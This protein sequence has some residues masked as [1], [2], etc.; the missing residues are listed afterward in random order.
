MKIRYY[1]HVGQRTGYARAA[2]DMC[3]ALVRAGVTLEI[4]PLALPKDVS[5]TPEILPL[6]RCL[7]RDHEL[8]P[9]PDI[10]IVHT[11]P[12]DCARVIEVAMTGVDPKLDPAIPRIAY[13]TWET[14]DDAPIAIRQS[15]E[16]FQQVW[17]PSNHSLDALAGTQGMEDGAKEHYRRR[18]T[19]VPHCF[20]EESLALRR[21]V[22][23]YVQGGPG[24]RFKFYYLGAWNSRKN[25]SGLIRAFTYE[26]RPDDPVALILRSSGTHRHH[27]LGAMHQCG[28]DSKEMPQ[29]LFNNEHMIHDDVLAL[30]RDADCFVTASRGEAWN[31]PAFE[32]MLAGRQ[33]ITPGHQGS[34]AYL[35][36]DTDALSVG[37]P[38]A[39]AWV[40]VAIGPG[41]D[42][43]PPGAYSVQQVGATGLTCRSVWGEPNLVDMAA[44]MREVFQARK[45]NLTIKFNPLER[46]G[47]TVV[48]RQAISA[49]E[50]IIR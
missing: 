21:D 8:S 34:E 3:M 45:R 37:A 32:A 50:G 11:L 4:R 47:Y 17:S 22:S 39:F 24:A 38:S 33:I 2:N 42:T 13:T 6:A 1:G 19:Q 41:R 36:P 49:M 44:K 40:D 12:S 31:L 35:Y 46:Y 48:A 25:V 15:L 27:F 5:I 18:Y 9:D 26:F 43:D 14:R 23:E 29:I 28:L 10:V 20:D 16:S 30:H 7:R